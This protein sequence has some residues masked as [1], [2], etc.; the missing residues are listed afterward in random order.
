V[1]A[2]YR[3]TVEFQVSGD[4]ALFSDPVTRVGGEKFIIRFLPMKLSKG[5]CK[6]YIGN[7]R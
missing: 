6:V 4:Y 5:F 7:R 1:Q 2:K 3:N